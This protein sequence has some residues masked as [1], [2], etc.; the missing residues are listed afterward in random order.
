MDR[1]D[2]LWDTLDVEKV[3]AS[4]YYSKDSVDQQVISDKALIHVS[5]SAGT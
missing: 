4:D 5:P 1:N 2:L 3:F